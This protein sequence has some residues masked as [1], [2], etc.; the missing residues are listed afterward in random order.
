MFHAGDGNLHPLICYDDAMPGQA[1]HAETVASEILH[2]CIDA[3]GA[4]TGEHGV[5]A[6]KKQYMSEMFAPVDLD[7]MQ[8]VRCAFDPGNICNPGKVFPTPRL[9]GEVPGPY[10]RIRS[11][12]LAWRSACD[13]RLLRTSHRGRSSH[14]PREGHHGTHTGGGAGPRHQ[15]LGPH[16]RTWRPMA[17]S[18]RL[19]T[20]GLQ[21]YAGDLVAT[22]PAGMTLQAVN[23]TLA[24]ERQ[25]IPLDPPFSASATIG[26]IVSANDSGPRR[27]HF[28][29]PRDLV[30]GMQVAL[31]NG[32]VAHSGGRVVKNVAGYDLGRLFCGS[33]GSLGV[34]ASVTFKLAPTAPASRT[35]L[36]TFADLRSAVTTAQALARR[37]SHAPTA[38]ELIGPDPR[39]LVRYETT[40]ASAMQFSTHL[41]ESL[42]VTAGEVRILDGAE[43]AAAWAA[44][45]H[46]ESAEDGLVCQVSMLPAACGAFLDAAAQVVAAHG[47][48]W[49][50]TGRPALGVMRLHLT[51]AD[52]ATGRVAPA[53]RQ[54]ASFHDGHLQF[55]RGTSLLPAGTNAMPSTGTAAAIG[56]AVKQRFDPNGILPYPWGRA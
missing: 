18:T 27:H 41:A 39:V 15:A 20:G 9:C 29:S 53:V 32:T 46:L 8:L 10:R 55:V 40:S 17:L 56:L 19:L 37:A 25:W 12:S 14:H 22:V 4:I 47:L 26:G 33:H 45:Q 7:T 38:V 44:H 50:V 42:R 34:I 16:R 24:A 49:T 30:I 43:E 54:L 36:A 48:R 6:D 11:S 3:G 52:E 28:G 5:G 1:A 13:G 51:G 23:E 2:Y 35:V 21:H 31:A